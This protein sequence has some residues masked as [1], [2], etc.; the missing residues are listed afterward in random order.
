M[1]SNI[2]DD[3]WHK[4]CCN[5]LAVYGDRGRYPRAFR[6]GLSDA[7]LESWRKMGSDGAR[8]ADEWSVLRGV[9][10]VAAVTA[11][12]FK[13]PSTSNFHNTAD[14]S[15]AAPD[16]VLALYCSWQRGRIA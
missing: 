13:L 12:Y 15:R 4:V 9:G 7:R 8:C 16:E 2:R 11:G 1:N 14:S 10:S 3:I 5:S 6:S